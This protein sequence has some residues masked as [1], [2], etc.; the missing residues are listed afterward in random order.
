GPAATAYY[1]S[2]II[3]YTPAKKDQEHIPTI[4]FSNTQV[5]DRTKS[6]L[7]DEHKAIIEELTESVKKLEQAGADF[8]TIPCNTAHYYV[9]YM[10]KAVSIPVVDMLEIAIE[11]IKSD[12]KKEEKEGN[13]KVMVLATEGTIK[14][15]IYHE[16]LRKHNLAPIV[17]EK[18][19]QEK[20]MSIIYGIKK[21]GATDEFRNRFE[22]IVRKINDVD[23]IIAGCTELSML[24]EEETEQPKLFDPLKI[25][26]RYSVQKALEEDK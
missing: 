14:T 20:I 24:V 2:L 19:T 15:K 1:Y 21:I 25:L 5:P 9:D 6:I 16:R 26:A 23:Y 3:K 17:Q 12:A 11:E 7:N 22:N 4:I 10:R 18:D 13:I 8:I